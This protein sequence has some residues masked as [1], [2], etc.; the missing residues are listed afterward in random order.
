MRISLVMI[1]SG[2]GG[3]QQTIVPYCDALRAAGNDMQVVLYRKSP[4]IGE[5][6]SLGIEPD[7][8]PFRCQNKVMTRLTQ[9]LLR[10][11]LKAFRPDI[12]IG[13]ASRG[14]P[15]ARRAM[16]R[17][18]PIITR[19]A[20]LKKKALTRLMGADGFVV[21]STHMKALLETYGVAPSSIRIVP[22]FLRR[23]LAMVQREGLR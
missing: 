3:V 13:F 20:S 23:P 19:V 5:I 16:G 10:R 1:A 12:I 2:A 18:V 7:F 8:V 17:G 22:N 15:Q 6:R 21:T 11:K 9:F 4:M 14:Y